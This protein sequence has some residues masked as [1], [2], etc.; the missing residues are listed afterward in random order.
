[1]REQLNN[2]TCL[3]E[4]LLPVDCL[5]GCSELQ[6]VTVSATK[7]SL[8]AVRAPVVTCNVNKCALHVTANLCTCIRKFLDTCII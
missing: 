1:M 3:M 8:H 6:S 5:W 7:R 4:V 2:I